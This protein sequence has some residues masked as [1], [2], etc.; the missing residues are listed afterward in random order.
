MG[1]DLT[2]PTLRWPNGIGGGPSV[3]ELTMD[4]SDLIMISG[5]VTKAMVAIQEG[6]ASAFGPSKDRLERMCVALGRTPEIVYEM[7]VPATDES[8]S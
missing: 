7:A 5:L 2:S 8:I 4:A 1:E 3:A 6:T